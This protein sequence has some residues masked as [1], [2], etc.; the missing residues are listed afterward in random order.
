LAA[1][2][3]PVSVE[4]PSAVAYVTYENPFY[5]IRMSYPS[6]LENEEGFR[7][8]NILSFSPE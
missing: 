2:G 8:D 1:E 7:R 3:V 5:G 4:A 6:Y